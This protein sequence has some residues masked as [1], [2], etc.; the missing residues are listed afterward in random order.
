MYHLK[1]NFIVSQ[2]KLDHLSSGKIHFYDGYINLISNLYFLLRDRMKLKIPVGMG[3]D[4]DV[5]L[6]GL[7]A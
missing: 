5:I 3:E 1:R 7:I 6:Y 2:V 4:R